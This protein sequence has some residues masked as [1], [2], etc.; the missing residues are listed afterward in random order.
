MSMVNLGLRAGVWTV[1]AAVLALAS[2]FSPARALDVS[3]MAGWWIAIDDSL[4]KYWKQGAVAPMEEIVQITPEGVVSNRVMNLSARGPHCADGRDC[5]DL[6]AMASARVRVSGNQM[7]F[8][9]IVAS[10]ARL[11][12]IAGNLLIRQEALTAT[13]EWTVTVESGERVTLRAA[14]GAKVRRM[15]RIDPDKLRKLHAGMRVS[16]WPA[17]E[18]WRCFLTHATAGEAAFAPLQ[19]NRSYRRPEF[20]ERYLKFASYLAAIHAAVDAAA[21]PAVAASDSSLAVPL[22]NIALP[23][24]ADDRQRL[25]A[26][27]T[28]ANEHARAMN[29]FNIASATAAAAKSKAANAQKDAADK[30][31]AAKSAATAATA[32]TTRAA[33]DLAEHERNHVVATAQAQTAKNATAAAAEAEVVAA[34]KENN[35]K[36]MA[37]A[38]DALRRLARVQLQK[39]RAA[40]SYAADQQE[41]YDAAIR[42]ITAQSQLA[43]QAK[44]RVTEQQKD[45]AATAKAAG[46]QQQKADA[47]RSTAESLKRKY[48]ALR[49][50]AVAQ[51]HKSG[52]YTASAQGFAE[53]VT[54]AQK[55]VEEATGTLVRRT[56]GSLRRR[57]CAR[58]GHSNSR[59]QWSDA[60]ADANRRKPAGGPQPRRCGPRPVGSRCAS[61]IRRSRPVGQCGQGSRGRGDAR[62]RGCECGAGACQRSKGQGRSR[63]PGGSPVDRGSA[64]RRTAG[65]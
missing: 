3:D 40:R 41:R 9:N 54:V 63:R 53:A 30:E 2:A 18:H 12:S 16:G 4:P 31:V 36:A 44:L 32:A 23:L 37:A 59:D 45:A 7:E 8:S 28:Y 25:N 14:G 33:A 1:A 39:A 47:A 56:L 24:S 38:A 11:D 15:V 51:Q 6:P 10:D 65:R 34:L 35:S 20:L 46:E 61:R 49:L 52:T 58:G 21:E 43:E 26:V 48:E 50:A 62:H 22:E 60:G 42:G 29:A 5:S 27:L 13:P 64:R 19:P 55:A 57:C 17:D